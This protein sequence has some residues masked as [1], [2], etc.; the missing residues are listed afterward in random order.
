[1]LLFEGEALPGHGLSHN[2]RGLT[3]IIAKRVE[4]FQLNFMS[5]HVER[6]NRKARPP[7]A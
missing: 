3:M 1:M 6:S 2:A 7:L 4:R 5:L